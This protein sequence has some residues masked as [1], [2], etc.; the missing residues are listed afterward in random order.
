MKKCL[1]ILLNTENYIL[2]MHLKGARQ[3]FTGER[4]TET[5]HSRIRLSAHNKQ[6]EAIRVIFFFGL[7]VVFTSSFWPSSEALNY[8]IIT[9]NHTFININHT[10]HHLSPHLA[11]SRNDNAMCHPPGECIKIQNSY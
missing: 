3:T 11:A 5:L 10:F 8:Q 9:I 6:S 2:A 7:F 1:L 4:K